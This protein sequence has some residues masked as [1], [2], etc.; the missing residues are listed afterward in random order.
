MASRI[1]NIVG[2]QSRY[3]N[4]DHGIRNASGLFPLQSHEIL[5]NVAPIGKKKSLDDINKRSQLVIRKVCVHAM[6]HDRIA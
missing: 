6:H 3:F 1:L 2:R 4:Y 5:V